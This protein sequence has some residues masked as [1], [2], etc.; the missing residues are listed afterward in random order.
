M[1][2]FC[3]YCGKLL[4]EGEACDCRSQPVEAQAENISEQPVQAASAA[5][6]VGIQTDKIKEIASGYMA[7]LKAVF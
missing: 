1:A 4:Q 2:K 3:S 6:N 7:F 5:E